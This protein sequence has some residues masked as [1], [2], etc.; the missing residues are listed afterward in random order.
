MTRA[1]QMRRDLRIAFEFRAGIP[2]AE[3]AAAHGISVRTVGRA[4][5]RVTQMGTTTGAAVEELSRR[6]TELTAAIEDLAI[7][8]VGGSRAE[9]LC[10]QLPLLRERHE[11]RLE[12]AR[13]VPAEQLASGVDGI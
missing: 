5:W 12:L 13:L 11:V 7:G 9:A 8:R 6:Y 2:Q 10:E 4:V 3:I 1:D